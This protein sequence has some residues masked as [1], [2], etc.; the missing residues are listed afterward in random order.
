MRTFE[1]VI[2]LLNL[3]ALAALVI[4]FFRQ[5]GRL[6]FLPAVIAGI[7][8]VHLVVEQYRWQMVP[9]YVMT[10]ALFLFTLPNLLKGAV[11]SFGGVRAA[12]IGG[13]GLPVWLIAAVLPI[14][15]PVPIPPT[16]P[17]PYA[18]GSV[19]YDWTDT[20]RAE[21][22][23][24]NPNDKREL[25]VQVWYP[26]QVGAQARTV[27]YV[28]NPDVA[29]PVLAKLSKLPAF[30]LGH[31]GLVK[32]HSYQDVPVRNDGAPYPIVIYSHGYTGYR[33]AS[34]AQMEALAS[35]GYIAVAID[36]TYAAGFTVFPDG[37]VALNNPAMLPAA[38]GTQPGDQE[39]R[40]KAAAIAVADQR[41]VM[42]QLEQLNAGRL[43]SRF[44]GKLD[45]QRIGLTGVSYGAAMVWTC[46]LD[47]RCK[48]G[49][50]QDGW[51]ETFPEAIVAEPL[52]QPFMFMQSETQMWKM[53][54]LA[55]LDKIYQRVNAPAY[56][57]K[58]AGVLHQDFGDYPLL[59]P[60]TGVLTERGTL[61]GERT[62]KMIDAYIVAFFDKYLK[63]QP[64]P[65][66][67]GPSRDYPEARF[68]SHGP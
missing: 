38:G 39:L 41:F 20:A 63:N 16:P 36:H 60:L 8:L 51:Y 17:G 33:T 40:E 52:R 55:R 19:I 47:A 32:T 57:I 56:H 44:A 7:T 21:T 31:L 2:V 29:I 45:L 64:A 1:V 6:R 68:E 11:A 3:L 58:F 50:T 42:D 15:L 62:V 13:V 10:A 23:S 14:I 27:P 49:L 12:L 54:N 67:D 25:V 9:S 28:D 5:F 66:L 61:N 30:A 18:I 37:R 22:Y 53:D 34:F 4:P 59:T 65:L 48:A 35:S 24:S 46:H 26:A 43:D